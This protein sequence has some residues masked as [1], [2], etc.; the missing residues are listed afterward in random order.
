MIIMKIK[1]DFLLKLKLS[2]A[3]QSALCFSLSFREASRDGS[4]SIQLMLFGDAPGDVAP[5]MIAWSPSAFMTLGVL[6][7]GLSDKW[8]T[9]P[10][11]RGFLLH[12]EGISR[13]S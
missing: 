9:L 5:E 11:G 4:R 13:G 10:Y 1:V 8:A 12:A 3:A 7:S 6:S 2:S